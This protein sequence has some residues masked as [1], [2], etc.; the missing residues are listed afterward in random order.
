MKSLACPQFHCDDG[1]HPE[2]LL[3]RGSLTAALDEAVRVGQAEA[4]AGFLQ[5]LL[6][7][8]LTASSTDSPGGSALTGDPAVASVLRITLINAPHLRGRYQGFL[9]LADARLDTIARQRLQTARERLRLRL[10]LAR[11]EYSLR[12]G[13]VGLG[14][15]LLQRPDAAQ[16]PML[17]QVVAYAVELVLSSGEA[18]RPGW[19]VPHSPL[20]DLS[21]AEDWPDGHACFTLLDGSAGL[22]ALLAV[23]RLRDVRV[24][25]LNAALRSVSAWHDAHRLTD[26]HGR[27]HWPE[28]VADPQPDPRPIA[29]QAAD[30]QGPGVCG[31]LGIARATQLAG[32]A[33]NDPA[34]RR[35]AV[36]AARTALTRD[37]HLF[38]TGGICHGPHGAALA[39]LRIA[40]DEPGDHAVGLAEAAGTL[41][42]TVHPDARHAD[43]HGGLLDG[44]VGE[45]ITRSNGD[46]RIALPPDEA[47]AWDSLLL[48]A[49]R[50]APAPVP[51]RA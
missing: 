50:C 42:R 33:R 4:D 28:V 38:E 21:Q 22:M 34:L 23:A 8:A 16:D 13:L 9:D 32:L 51:A 46:P 30:A 29:H 1:G 25:R 49:Q 39:A 19:W 11:A 24:P 5:D 36:A 6:D 47:A 44:T 15:C 31:N 14:A 35:T 10:P 27:P 7:Q 37:A 48:L 17:V 3:Y 41:I 20:D 43:P 40:A 26:E 2:T 12:E 45:H 18:G